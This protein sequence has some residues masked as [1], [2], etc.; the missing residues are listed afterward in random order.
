MG[1]KYSDTLKGVEEIAKGLKP[2][3]TAS[4][5]NTITPM[6]SAPLGGAGTGAAQ[7]LMA[8][9][10]KQKRGQYGLSLTG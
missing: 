2:K 5:L 1:Q 8:E 10:V 3:S 4:D 7:Q 9:L 6:S